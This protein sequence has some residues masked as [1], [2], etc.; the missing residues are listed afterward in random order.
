MNYQQMYE[1]LLAEF[2]QY[3]R[4]SV[5]WSVEDFL[6]YNDTYADEG[7]YIT[8][9]RAQEALERMIRKHDAD[10]GISWQ[11]VEFYFKEYAYNSMKEFLVKDKSGRMDKPATIDVGTLFKYWKL[12]DTSDDDV[13]LEDYLINCELGDTFK[14]NSYSI[15]CIKD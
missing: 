3:K 7:L 6:A 15:T 10:W 1:E 5:K 2:E 4:E 8:T 9:E 14:T 12:D 13:V 11:E